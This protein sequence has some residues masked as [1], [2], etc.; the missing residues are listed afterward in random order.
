MAFILPPLPIFLLT[1]PN[2]TVFTKEILISVILTL[3]G[4][5]P[6]I[7]FSLYVIFLQYNRSRDGYDSIDGDALLGRQPA[8]NNH[9]ESHDSSHHH[10]HDGTPQS[11]APQVHQPYHDDVAHEE[12]PHYTEV[13]S[14]STKHNT[15][16]TK[17]VD[18]KVQH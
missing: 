5:V 7:I 6:G 1:G 14:G 17:G 16:D 13:A 10:H 9:V 11:I 12:P 4:H 8:T 18:N 15:R 3:F 2:Y